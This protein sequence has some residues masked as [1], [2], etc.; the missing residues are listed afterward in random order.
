[1][2]F[3][4]EPFFNNA[5][6]SLDG[7]EYFMRRSSSHSGGSRAGS[8]LNFIRASSRALFKLHVYLKDQRVS[9]YIAPNWTL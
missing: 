6:V 9:K 5:Q 4:E 2:N 1:M 8:W 3:S 7:Y